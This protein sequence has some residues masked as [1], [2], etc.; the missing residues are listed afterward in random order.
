MEDLLDME[1]NVI[2]HAIATIGNFKRSE[3]CLVEDDHG[4]HAL[5]Y[6]L[7]RSVP[8]LFDVSGNRKKRKVGST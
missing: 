6:Q 1:L 8:S 3:F 5:L 4:G 2:V 7:I